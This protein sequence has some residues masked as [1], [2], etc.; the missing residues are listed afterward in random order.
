VRGRSAI[1]LA[2]LIVA[3]VAIRAAYFRQLDHS[4]LIQM[5][6]SSQTDMHYYD[7]WARQIAAGDWRSSLVRIPMH[8]WHREVAAAYLGAHPDVR[9]TLEREAKEATE[10]PDAQERLWAQW[11]QAPRFYQDPLYPYAIASIYR[12]VAADAR[13]VIAAQLAVGVLTNVLVWWI[14]R[15]YFGELAGA[16]A[17]ALAV[18]CAP[19]VF[20]EGLLLRDSLIAFTGLAIVWMTDRALRSRGV[21][22]WL[23]LGLALGAACLLKSS[24]LLLVAALAAGVLGATGR[25]GGQ[26]S[27]LSDP[28]PGP[29]APRR[30][31]GHRGSGLQNVATRCQVDPSPLR[32][33][34]GRPPTWH[35]DLSVC[36]PDP[37]SPA[38]LPSGRGPAGLGV[39]SAKRR[40]MV[41]G[42]SLA[43]RTRQG[44]PPIWHRDLSVCT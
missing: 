22:P 38:C 9:A 30:A 39:R 7:G 34:Q 2:L 27:K 3:S 25:V 20:Y 13:W 35:R 17:A 23:V 8:R 12:A 33:R 26:V 29:A 43:L 16:S 44:R 19:L 42:R 14:A 36:R 37:Q 10:G 31:R 15:R 5:H 40:D 21:A 32:T 18:L 41:P 1:L 24:F 6:R 11:M 28:V 4:P